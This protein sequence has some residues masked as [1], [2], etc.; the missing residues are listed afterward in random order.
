MSLAKAFPLQYNPV[1]D[2]ETDEDEETE[3]DE[4]NEET[5][6]DEETEEEEKAEDAQMNALDLWRRAAIESFSNRVE[7]FPDLPESPATLPSA[8]EAYHTKTSVVML[9]SLDRNMLVYPLPT[10]LSFNLPRL[11]KNVERIDIVQVKFLCGLYNIS[12]TLRNN[13]F[14]LTDSTST[15]T[16]LTIPSG[17]YGVQQL[18]ATLQGLLNGVGSSSTF[19]VTWS[20][21]TGRITIAGT[22]PF[23]IS[24]FKTPLPTSLISAKVEWGLGYTLGWN[25][26]PATLTGAASY[27]APCF[28]RVDKD[29]VF[30]QMNDSERMN[31]VTTS[32][33]VGHYFGK[34]LL[35]E[36]GAY[37]QSFVEA[38]KIYELPLG[39]LERLQFAWT[40]RHGSPLVGPD[41]ATCDW[42]MTLRITERVYAKEES[43]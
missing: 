15:V 43:T 31:E 4:E 35:N 13:T 38:P 19:S 29:Y 23:F 2:E 36:F 5:E 16:T 34:L 17:F 3:E 1:I 37:A 28:P 18:T 12:P 26:P 24:L 32:D 14:T 6:E 42:H 21:T 41:A 9:D 30:L 8:P 10:Q 25:G 20:P 39:R 27:T 7:E 33:Q 22:A 40:D 11:F